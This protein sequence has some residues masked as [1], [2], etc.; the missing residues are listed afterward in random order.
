MREN[1]WEV[2]A[3]ESLDEYLASGKVAPIW[4]F[5][6]LHLERLGD[7]VLGNAVALRRDREA[8]G[9]GRRNLRP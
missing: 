7:D 1:G 9:L 3:W 5:T 2:R 6:R 4:Y 8:E